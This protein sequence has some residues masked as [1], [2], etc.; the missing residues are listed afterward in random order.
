MLVADTASRTV[1]HLA[2]QAVHRAKAAPALAAADRTAA[3]A[4]TSTV[5]A[6]RVPARV[7]GLPVAGV[8]AFALR[9]IGDWIGDRVDDVRSAGGALLG[10]ARDMIDIA[11]DVIGVGARRLAALPNDAANA[12]ANSMRGPS[13]RELTSGEE[14]ALREVFGDSIDLSDVRIV[15]GP[16]YNPDAVAAFK[17]GGNPALTEGDTVYLRGDRYSADLSATPSGTN[18]LVH[19]FAHVRQYQQMG[20]GSFFA[21]YGRDLAQHGFDRNEPY[22]YQSRDLDFDAETLEGQAEMVGDYAGYLAGEQGGISATEA[23]EIEAKLRGT[24][25]FGL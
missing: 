4:A 14:A 11:T 10:S 8:Q 21:K 22:D 19:E 16:G 13:A 24:G 20:F 17:V 6:A 1:H 3:S 5:A 25:L 2:S 9:G 7:V 23:R 15:R 18:L 12:L